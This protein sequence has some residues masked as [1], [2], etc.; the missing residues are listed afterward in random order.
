MLKLESS[1]CVVCFRSES[2]HVDGS[3]RDPKGASTL[4]PHLAATIGECGRSWCAGAGIP[5]Y[6]RLQ[7]VAEREGE[8]VNHKRLWRVHREA[9]LCLKQK[10]RRHCVHVGSPRPALT[11]ANQE[12]ALDFAHNVIAAGRNIRVLSIVDA[13]TRGCLA[14]QVDADFASRRVTR[15]LDEI[16][17]VRGR[18]MAIPCDNG[19][20]LTSRHFRHGPWSGRLKC[21]TFSR[22]SRRRTRM[23][24]AS[25]ATC[26]RIDC[27]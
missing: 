19:P 24:R 15:V 6:R 11:G 5:R 25:T 12:L 4:D 1:R 17:V 3:P 21:D 20:A 2:I 22:A 18:P 23:W 10:K 9:G 27:R 16:F 13:F 7:V 26:A 14:L 8:R